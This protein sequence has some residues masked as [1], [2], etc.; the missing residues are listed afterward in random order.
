ML[1]WV[2]GLLQRS[3]LPLLLLLL[4]S[5]HWALLGLGVSLS[6]TFVIACAEFGA[7]CIDLTNAY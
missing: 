3:A 4:P 1:F 5:L 6:S 2:L 7:Y